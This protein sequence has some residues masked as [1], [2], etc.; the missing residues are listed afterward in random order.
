MPRSHSAHVE[1]AGLQQPDEDVLDVLTDV[2]GLG[3]RR[4]IGDG[5]GDVENARERLGEQRLA[6]AGG[7]EEQ[8]VRLVE[9][10]IS[11]AV[12]RTAIDALVVVVDRDGQVRLA[13]SC[14]IDILI[15]HVLDL[16]RR[17]NRVLP[18][19]DLPLFVL[20]QD[21]VAERDALVADVDRRAGN[22][23][24]DR[25]LALAAEAS[26][27]DACRWTWRRFR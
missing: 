16:L 22:E 14:P 23:L 12:A 9:L 6:D 19:G 13:R 2:A 21:L 5:E 24:P 3:E 11:L 10:D 7:A 25:V 17:G 20:R 8:D 1:I 4:G 26:N 27:G 18:L 15:Q